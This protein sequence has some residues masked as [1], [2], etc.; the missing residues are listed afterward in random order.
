M[1]KEFLWILYNDKQLLLKSDVESLKHYITFSN[2]GN[3]SLDKI[4]NNAFSVLACMHVRA[5]LVTSQFQASIM[6]RY[7]N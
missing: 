4:P 1:V 3:A 7:H 2:H 5:R 6:Y